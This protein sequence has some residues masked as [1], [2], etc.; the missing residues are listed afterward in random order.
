MLLGEVVEIPVVVSLA[1]ITATLAVAVGAS[2]LRKPAG[3]APRKSR[4]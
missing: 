3:A 2:L 1:V 4:V